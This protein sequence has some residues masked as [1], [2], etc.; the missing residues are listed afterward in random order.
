MFPTYIILVVL[1]MVFITKCSSRFAR[2]IGRGNP[3]ATLAT[4]V[5][6]CYAKLLRTTI[7]ML[8]SASLTYPDGTHE[9][10]WLPD[11]NVKYFQGKHVPLFLTA[12]IIVTT[13]LA[14]TTLLSLDCLS[15][16]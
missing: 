4:I 1:V 2:L 6:L 11:A 3:A 8:S 10:V 14:Y 15:K 13:G 7:D 16:S 9:L 12:I 5:L